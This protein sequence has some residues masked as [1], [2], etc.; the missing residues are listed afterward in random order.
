MRPVPL[1]LALILLVAVIDL[2][3]RR[4]LREEFSWLWVLGAGA[5]LVLGAWA[6]AR[7]AIAHVLGV[8]EGL[9]MVSLGLLFLVL[10]ALDISTKVSRLANHQKSLAQSLGRIEKRLG[11]VE[12]RLQDD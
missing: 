10:V 11:D 2:V 8:D 4:H 1:L 6:G 12:N 7:A 5:A 9:A 3:R